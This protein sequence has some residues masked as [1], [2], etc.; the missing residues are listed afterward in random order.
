MLERTLT[1]FGLRVA[2]AVI[3]LGY[4]FWLARVLSAEDFGVTFYIITMATLG[5]GLVTSG[6]AAA[7][8]RLGAPA[9]SQGRIADLRRLL[10]RGLLAA[11]GGTA[12]LAT[13]LWVGAQLTPNNLIYAS[14]NLPWFLVVMV[15]ASAMIQLLANGYL[16]TNDLVTAVL[17]TSLLRVG[18]PLALTAGLAVWV[19]L[20]AAAAVAGFAIG[21][22]SVAIIMAVALARRIARGPKVMSGPETVPAMQSSERRTIGWL[23]VVGLA[24][25]LSQNADALLIGSLLGAV[26]AG[27]YLAAKRVA[28]MIDLVADAVRLTAGP[29]F[30]VLFAR[31][32]SGVDFRRAVAE[33]N[34]LFLILVGTAC[35]CLAII[36]WPVLALF[37]PDFT[38]AYPVLLILIAGVASFAIFGP[39]GLLMTM[40]RLER[41][42]AMVTIGGGILS[43]A[44]VLLLVPLDG[45]FGGMN[46]AAI[47]IA[48]A[49]YVTNALSSL[50]IYREL[51][52]PPA[53]IDGDAYRLL[54][55]AGINGLR[56]AMTR[57]RVSKDDAKD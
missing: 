25:I 5:A 14:P 21:T 56:A 42:R 37:G 4:A 7:M 36:G 40:S 17:S 41:A 46:G 18:V 9:W 43:C 8:L 49:S 1:A 16:A 44:G 28:A 3:W 11:A 53:I 20:D 38:A 24:R 34:L 52:L 48:T 2:G 6:Y 35:M 31:D 45:P 26:E 30:A 10:M 13:L 19:Q 39:V 23:W 32:P 22:A 29:R 54:R 12:V 51:G 33:A 57:K 15:A 27:L 55:R 50:I 47:T